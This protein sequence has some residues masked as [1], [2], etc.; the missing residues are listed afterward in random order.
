MR[1]D[2]AATIGIT[3]ALTACGGAEMSND[4]VLAPADGADNTVSSPNDST[5]DDGGP[6]SSDTGTDIE[7]AWWSLTGELV[8]TSGLIQAGAGTW[9]VSLW[10]EEETALPCAFDVEIA[11]ASVEEAP[12]VEAGTLVSWWALELDEVPEEG[13]CPAWPAAELNVGLG[14]YDGRLDAASDAHE[15]LG[16]DL[17]GLYLQLDPDDPVLVAGVAG[18]EAQFHGEEGTVVG[19]PLPD[20][21]YVAATLIL[22]AL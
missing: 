18:T 14:P 21:T 2:R 7:P 10:G 3:L 8:V 16:L 9:S 4:R 12:S 1:W 19:P 15:W 22:L 13:A 20:G 5:P 6:P 11:S 17:Y